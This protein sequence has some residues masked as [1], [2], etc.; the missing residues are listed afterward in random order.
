M[1]EGICK[2]FDMKRMSH[3]MLMLGVCFCSCA[4]VSADIDSVLV[5][6][7]WP[8]STDVKVEYRLSN[9]T[10]PVNIKVECFNNGKPLTVENIDKAITGKTYSLSKADEGIGFFYI[11]PVKAFGKSQVSLAN[12]TVKLMLSESNAIDSEPIYRIIDLETKQVTDL[13]RADFYNDR[14]RKYGAY[15][16]SFAAIGY[17]PAMGEEYPYTTSLEDVFIWTG[18]TNDIAY[19]TTKLVMRRIPAKNKTFMMGG[20]NDFAKTDAENYSLE[21]SFTND[22]WLA[23]FET[24]CKQAQLLQGYVD[25]AASLTDAEAVIAADRIA[26]IDSTVGT[27]YKNIRGNPSEWEGWPENVYA[28]AS[29]SALGR[30]RSVFPKLNFDVPTEAQWE[31]ACRA[32]TETMYYSGVNPDNSA[33]DYIAEVSEL[34]WNSHNSGSSL[35]AV[36]LKKSNAFGLYDMLG[37]VGEL[38][39]DL[40]NPETAIWTNSA[41]GKSEMIGPAYPTITEEPS[42]WM[43]KEAVL[44]VDEGCVTLFRGE[45]SWRKYNRVKSSCRRGCYAKV[46]G[47][48]GSYFG[49]RLF[50]PMEQN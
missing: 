41:N 19:K 2:P 44:A 25:A 27:S 18:V 33:D 32:G 40:H 24:T 50:L 26:K 43:D 28:V 23:V 36:G 16:T 49:V 38:T 42:G 45:N 17:S 6:Q 46:D 22:Y 30:I 20:A 13:S 14:G 34:S 35:H 3:L 7:Q 9:V 48:Y 10:V 21:V 15:E 29:D 1:L 11:D 47:R 5:R 39:R 8:W 31:Y 37:N 12:F 4:G